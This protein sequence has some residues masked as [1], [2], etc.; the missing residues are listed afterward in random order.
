MNI[1]R[2]LRAKVI[3]LLH[4]RKLLNHMEHGNADYVR[5]HHA[6]QCP[7]RFNTSESGSK[8]ST[9]NSYIRFTSHRK[10]TNKQG[11]SD[12][13]VSLSSIFGRAS[14]ASGPARA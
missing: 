10:G 11:I 4:L 13:L 9:K 7:S 6:C 1:I 5:M 3:G 8:E 2:I 14:L 12:S